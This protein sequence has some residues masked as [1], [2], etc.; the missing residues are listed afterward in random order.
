MKKYSS[1]L[2]FIFI[3]MSSGCSTKYMG[4]GLNDFHKSSEL[5]AESMTG[6]ITEIIDQE[7]EL[8]AER[9]VIKSSITASD[10]EPVILTFNNL[11]LRKELVNCL[12]E[13]SGLLKA[14]LDKDH[15]TFV[16]EYGE[17]L[18]ESLN[19]INTS[20]P[21]LVSKEAGGIIS[22]IITMVPEGVTFMKKR[23]FALKLMGEMQKVIDKV[24][25]KLKE[26]INSLK[27]LA[28]NLYTRLFREKIENKWP[29]KKEKRLKYALAGVK[30]IKKRERFGLL[31]DDLIKIMDI[32]PVEH[33]RLMDSFRKSGGTLIGL[34]ELL[35]Y[36]LRL[37]NNYDLFSK[38][39]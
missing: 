37:K 18:R 5:I 35:N 25:V 39:E 15:I 13:Y 10:L 1:I 29:D 17:D 30:I 38:G 21:G 8:R 6:V 2:L 24:S 3:I 32:F 9:S 31:V 36:S 33:K 22:T 23:K 20:D 19:N 7:M 26:E 27:L 12:V 34:N 11:R 4:A 28:P 14:L 16:R